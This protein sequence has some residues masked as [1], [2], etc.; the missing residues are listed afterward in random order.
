MGVVLVRKVTFVLAVGALLLNSLVVLA[1]PSGSASAQLVL[2]AVVSI[3]VTDQWENL[4]I[5]QGDIAGWSGGTI[6]DWDSGSN[7]IVVVVKALTDFNLW[8]CYYAKEGAN[9]VDPFFGDA[10]DLVFLYD[11][12]NTYTLTYEEIT[13][14]SAYTGPY[15]T[16]VLTLL[17]SF[18]GDNNISTGGTTKNYEVK[19]KPENLGDRETDEEITFTIV[20]VVEE[21]NNL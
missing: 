1:A 16:S 8:G 3:S 19:L 5:E 2:N 12:A 21:K 18:T 7:D 9:D 17:Y 15:S 10:E 6:I 14:P 4:A 13:N 20:F 11:G